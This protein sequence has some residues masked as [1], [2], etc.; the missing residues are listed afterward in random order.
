MAWLDTT[1]TLRKPDEISDAASRNLFQRIAFSFY[2]GKVHGLVGHHWSRMQG[3]SHAGPPQ[4]LPVGQVNRKSDSR[5]KP[6]H[7]SADNGRRC[8][9]FAGSGFPNDLSRS[10]V[11]RV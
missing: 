11:Q 1:G 7:R 9:S 2:A 6:N 3:I 5:L 8:N 10:D 4:N